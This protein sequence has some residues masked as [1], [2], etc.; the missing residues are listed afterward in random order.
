LLEK[1]VKLRKSYRFLQEA[2]VNSLP[3]TAAEVLVDEVRRVICP[4]KIDAATWLEIVG[5]AHRLGLIPPVPCS[6]VILKPLAN[7]CST[8]KKL[9]NSKKSP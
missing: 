6:A 2:G 1:T 7:R 8:L 5:T 9:E 4:E 3:G